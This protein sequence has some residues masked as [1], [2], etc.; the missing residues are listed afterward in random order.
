MFFPF[1]NE[2]EVQYIFVEIHSCVII[3]LTYILLTYG[4]GLIIIIN[5]KKIHF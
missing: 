3:I 2:E 4:F 1:F 5:N